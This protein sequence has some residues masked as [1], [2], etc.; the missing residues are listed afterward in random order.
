MSTTDFPPPTPD[1]EVVDIEQA[2]ASPEAKVAERP[3]PLSPIVDG[4]LFL[5]AIVIYFGQDAFQSLLSGDIKLSEIGVLG[6]DFW[7]PALIALGVLV[8]AI[9]FAFANWW[10]TRFVID[11]DEVRIERTFIAHQ[12][13]RIAFSKIQSVDIKQPLV[14]RLL[15]LAA[16]NIDVGANASKKIQYLKRDRAYKMRDFLMARA[17]RA[18]TSTRGFV[19]P[20][21]Q[22]AGAAPAAQASALSKP[23]VLEDVLGYDQVI[24]RVPVGRLIG[25]LVLSTGTIWGIAFIAIFVALGLLIPGDAAGL[26]LIGLLPAAFGYI[27]W[28]L[29]ELKEGFNYS[30]TWTSSG[31]KTTH[32][33]TELISRSVPVHRIQ[34]VQ[35]SQPLLWRLLGWKRVRIDVLGHGISSDDAGGGIL[36]LPVGSDDE[37]KRVLDVAIPQ[38]ELETIQMRPAGKKAR[39]I[40]WFDAQTFTWGFNDKAIVATGHILTHKVDIVPHARVQEVRLSQGILRRLLGLADVNAENTSG[41][42]DLCAKLLDAKDARKLALAEP[43]MMRTARSEML[44]NPQIEPITA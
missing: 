32:G 14:A 12:S 20:P 25:S 11:D 2:A 26:S 39:W 15:G 28:L 8:L 24:V 36:L 38:L 13:Q 31:L 18:Q 21:P 29:K 6:K 30:L 3:H 23:G 7:I 1:E 41:P 27:G 33:L 42:V 4:W 5:V 19:A 35:I 40:R 9:G 34:G 22:A 17:N 10:F 37:V 44:A 16:L 43:Q